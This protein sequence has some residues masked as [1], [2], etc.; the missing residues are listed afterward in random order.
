MRARERVYPDR[1]RP[2]IYL[3]ASLFGFLGVTMVFLSAR[4]LPHAGEFFSA[5]TVCLSGIVVSLQWLFRFPKTHRA[6]VIITNSALAAMIG[7]S[8]IALGTHFSRPETA[9]QLQ[10]LSIDAQ[11]LFGP[12]VTVVGT[13]ILGLL[14]YGLF[15]LK[16]K[17]LMVY[18]Y[19]EIVFALTSCW[20][21]VE[22][23]QQGFTMVTLTL[24]GGAVYLVVRGVE[25]RQKA[26]A[27]EQ[28]HYATSS[29]SL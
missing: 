19:A 6:D 24:I 29:R 12:F 22:R 1:A 13:C 21:A 23:S 28:S 3:T 8:V 7:A 9:V 16:T 20:V 14:G 27:A 26:V 5:V 25:N 2:G 15:V 18:A 10:A 17:A 4:H 11:K